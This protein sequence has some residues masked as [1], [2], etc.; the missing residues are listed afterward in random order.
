MVDALW[1]SFQACRWVVT[2]RVHIARAVIWFTK[3]TMRASFQVKSNVK[4]VGFGDICN[5]L[6]LQAMFFEQYM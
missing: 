4:V 3:R 1:N 2:F 5:N 6:N